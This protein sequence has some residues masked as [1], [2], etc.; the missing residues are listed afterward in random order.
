[1][2]WTA[3][4]RLGRL[5]RRQPKDTYAHL[6]DMEFLQ[7]YDDLV[8]RAVEEV[9]IDE[10]RSMLERECAEAGPARLDALIARGR[11]RRD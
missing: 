11:I 2:N 7:Y 1:M 4:R 3:L 5:E 8:V 6:S 9:G 10:T